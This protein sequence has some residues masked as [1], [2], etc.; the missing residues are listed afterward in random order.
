MHI[1]LSDD[2]CSDLSSLRDYLQP[3]SPQGYER[4]MTAI[5]TVLDQLETFPFLGH[6]GSIEG[7]R[8]MLVAK[9][10]YRIIYT[11]PDEFHIDVERIL[12]CRQKWPVE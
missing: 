8:E 1:R 10:P 2:A 3:N 11:L 12:S 6:D 7:T 4:V 9:Y 5:F